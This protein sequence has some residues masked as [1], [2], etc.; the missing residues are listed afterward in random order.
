MSLTP[1][2]RLLKDAKDAELESDGTTSAEEL[3]FLA[4]L[5]S[6]PD[7]HYIGEIGFN[8]GYSSYAFLAAKSTNRVYSFDL[9]KFTYSMPAKDYINEQFP[10][11]HTLIV[12]DSA[13]SVP[14]FHQNQPELRFDL[15]FVDGGHEYEE[16]SVDLKN[17]AMFA[18]TGTLVV[19]DDLTPWK[20][21]GVGPDQAWR[22]AQDNGLITQR[23]LIQ[24]G[25]PVDE[26]T[27]GERKSRVWALGTYALVD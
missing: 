6:Y 22:E 25:V 27:P 21:W 10:G 26:V 9:A 5:A 7:V 24:D 20:K 3:S 19:M 17:M 8:A 11:R 14:W 18:H 1:L 23:L 12:G 2:L 15:I 16:A 4:A 13:V